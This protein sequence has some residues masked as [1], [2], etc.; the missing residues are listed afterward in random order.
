MNIHKMFLGK[1]VH[2]PPFIHYEYFLGTAYGKEVT[3]G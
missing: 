1:K 2:A 3:G